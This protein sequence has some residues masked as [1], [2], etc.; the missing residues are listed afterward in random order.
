MFRGSA[1]AALLLATLVTS[2]ALAQDQDED[3][4]PVLVAKPGGHALLIWD[5]TTQVTDIVKNKMNDAAADDVLE[6]G[7]LAA[8]ASNRDALSRSASDV[9]VNIIFKKIGAINPEYGTPTYAGVYK[10]AVLKMDGNDVFGKRDGW[11]TLAASA[12]IPAWVHF[13][14]VGQLPPR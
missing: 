1:V 4:L 5:A 8:I 13:S 9:T 11:P 10:C 14:L 6:R 12:P 2:A 7:A 3:D